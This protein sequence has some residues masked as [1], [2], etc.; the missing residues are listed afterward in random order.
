MRAGIGPGAPPPSGATTT[1]RP[2]RRR[3]ARE[4]PTVMLG[5]ALTP[6]GSQGVGAKRAEVT[7]KAGQ[8]CGLQPDVG[9]VGA[10][11]HALDQ[12]PHDSRLLGQEQFN[13]PAGS[14]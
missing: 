8:P 11:V 10:D 13:A 9:T 12:E 14:G 7:D 1:F 6:R 4:T 2:P 5:A 3:I